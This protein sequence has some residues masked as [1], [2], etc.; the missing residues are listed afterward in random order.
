MSTTARTFVLVALIVALAIVGQ[1]S[2]D[3]TLR[4]LWRVPA[5]FLLI[6]IAAEAAWLRVRRF[7]LRVRTAPRVYLGRSF[8]AFV[9]L[10]N[11]SRGTIEV[12]LS[13]SIPRQLT[14]SASAGDTEAGAVLTLRARGNETITHEV[15]LVPIRLGHA[16]WPTLHA[17]LLGVF[18]LVWW[19]RSVPQQTM[20]D[21][22]PDL[23]RTPSTRATTADS[24]FRAGR[25]RGAGAELHQLR[26][27][28]GGDP[29]NRIDWKASA[30]RSELITRELTEDQHLDVVVALDAG[31]SSRLTAGRLDRLGMF[32]NVA[33][34][35]AEHAV[36]ND[37]RVGLVV[38]AERVLALVPPT[39]GR[40]GVIRVRAAL[41]SIGESRAESSPLAAAL[42]IR[43][44]ARHRSLVVLLTD[45]DDVTTGGELARAVHLLQ[46]KHLVIVAGVSAPEIDAMAAAEARRWLDP[47]TSLAAR[48]W[49]ARTRA[50]LASLRK[51]GTPVIAA[52]PAELE[53]AILDYYTRLR[54]ERRV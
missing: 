41:E 47:Y 40:P 52:R 19:S 28:Q 20:L 46:A 1:W 7:E 37:D 14:R 2:T 13:L 5:A 17:R 45:L 31:R 18:G 51:S 42:E 36:A 12:Q 25:T 15:W 9:T 10:E 48:E 44:L 3:S 43:S 35:F 16:E 4:G 30:R 49:Q 38:Y 11:A 21:V 27:Y 33:A 34:R 29:P 39:R 50:Q 8:P 53:A 6:A 24:G 26:S 54:R 32:A 23:L 22:A